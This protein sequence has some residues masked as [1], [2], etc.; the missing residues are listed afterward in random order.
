MSHEG[1][2]MKN[3]LVRFITLA[4]LILCAATV[5]SR[6]QA[7]TPARGGPQPP[8]G[9][10]MRGDGPAPTPKPFNITRVDPSLDAIIS[11][12]AKLEVMA[13]GFGI[14]EGVLWIREGNSGYLLLSSLI[15]NVMY[16]ITP[17]HN[18]SVFMERAGYS[19]NDP[20]NVGLQT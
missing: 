4:A 1:Y 9:P 8:A 14:N 11:P 20:S 10:Q 15:D 13:T 3:V 17:D 5:V 19:G 2:N 7:P 12:N 18:V 16:K 6:A